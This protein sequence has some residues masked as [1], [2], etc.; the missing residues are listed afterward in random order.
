[1]PRDG[2]RGGLI[3]PPSPPRL[4]L[5]RLARTLGIGTV[6]G[7]LFAHFQLPLAWMLGAMVLTT[8]GSLAGAKL[9]VPPRLRSV[10]VT[11]LGVL[12]GSA[13]VLELLRSFV[14]RR[15]VRRY[16]GSGM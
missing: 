14:W 2:L 6:G 3:A 10:M 11:I 13:L 9:H 16:T 7:F 4:P 8:S 5:A 1:M 12:L 15:G